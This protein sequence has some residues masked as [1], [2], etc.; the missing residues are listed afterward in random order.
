MEI[1]IVGMSDNN[2]VTHAL[3]RLHKEDVV[4]IVGTESPKDSEGDLAEMLIEVMKIRGPDAIA[5][6]EI[7]ADAYERKIYDSPKNEI[8]KS[9]VNK[10]HKKSFNHR[11][12]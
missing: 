10:Q 1:V 11:R 5:K 6:C 7:L 9:Q 12:K 4:V 3:S 2:S 8:R